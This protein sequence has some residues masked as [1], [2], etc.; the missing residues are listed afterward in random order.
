MTAESFVDHVNSLLRG[1]NRPDLTITIT[2]LINIDGVIIRLMYNGNVIGTHKIDGQTF[3]QRLNDS[4]FYIRFV[5][6]FLS[7]VRGHNMN[8]LILEY[9]DESIAERLGVMQ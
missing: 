1:Y 5:D 8:S 7:D 4:D 2:Y 9:L 6:S 3:Y